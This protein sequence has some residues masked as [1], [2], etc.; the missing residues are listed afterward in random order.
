MPR[1]KLKRWQAALLFYSIGYLIVF[2]FPSHGAPH[3][4]YTGSDP[5]YEVWNFR[6]PIFT[7]IF[8]DRYGFFYGPGIFLAIAFL[9]LSSLMVV[10][11]VVLAY[12]FFDRTKDT[13]SSKSLPAVDTK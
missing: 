8:D 6:F 3:F 12:Y 11:P 4:R 2:L 7:L 9:C 5:D 10:V 1:R 13:Q